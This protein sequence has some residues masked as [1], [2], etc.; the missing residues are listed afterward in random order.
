MLSLILSLAIVSWV[1][2]CRIKKKKIFP[3][4]FFFGRDES[5]EGED[6]CDG[7]KS[8][9]GEV[10]CDK[11]YGRLMALFLVPAFIVISY[12]GMITYILTYDSILA[13][14]NELESNIAKLE[15]QID[16]LDKSIE[17]LSINSNLSKEEAIA[18]NGLIAYKAELE[19]QIADN[20]TELSEMP[21]NIRNGRD[22]RKLYR[23][24][25]YF[26]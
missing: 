21:G 4:E 16:G 19:T 23:F 25:L 15:S 17:E 10:E 14:I 5:C 26:G 24:L 1:T 18:L 11:Y 13:K 8:C 7:D 20:N 3:K 12:H 9:D 2:Y 22:F 6:K